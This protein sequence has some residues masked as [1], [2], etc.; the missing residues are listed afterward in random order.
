M[1][2]ILKFLKKT[3]EDYETA[4]FKTYLHWCMAFATNYGNDLQK[5]V[6]NSSI[7][8]Y[9]NREHSKCEAK[10]L[11]LISFYHTE[12]GITPKEAQKLYDKCIFDMNNRFCKPL[13]DQAKKTNIYHDI[14]KN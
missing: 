9:Y 7:S 11:E 13:I 10:F 3:P 4:F 6:A 14:T 8:K 1:S 2:K 5:L 12:I